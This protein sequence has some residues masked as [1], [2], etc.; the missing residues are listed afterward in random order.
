MEW[1][2]TMAAEDAVHLGRCRTRTGWRVAVQGAD[3][4]LRLPVEDAEARSRLNRLPCR[5]R[6][7]LEGG[8]TALR[9]EDA[10]LPTAR[11]PDGLEWIELRTL[12]RPTVGGFAL[13]ARAPDPVELAP[14]RATAPRPAVGALLESACWRQWAEEV[15]AVRLAPL[16][17]ALADDGRVLVLGQPLPPLPGRPLVA[18]G[19]WLLPAGWRFPQP[20]D[21]ARLAERAS[22]GPRDLGL[23]HPDGTWE[24]LEGGVFV[25]ATRSAIRLSGARREAGGA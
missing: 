13:P 18:E 1:V 14:V 8:G 15:A 19:P 2:A 16:R 20:G 21:A 24:R 11:L 3:L 9:P 12:L 7:L 25:T 6:Y 5:Q 17:F 10:R 22:L 23:V 4:W